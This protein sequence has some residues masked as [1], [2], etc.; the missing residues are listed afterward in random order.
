[1]KMMTHILP[2]Q[3]PI[4]KESYIFMLVLFCIQNL[5]PK[6]HNFTDHDKRY[7]IFIV[8]LISSFILNV[9]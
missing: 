9:I 6:E 3:P 5:S 1:M 4:F 2:R 8:L 7:L